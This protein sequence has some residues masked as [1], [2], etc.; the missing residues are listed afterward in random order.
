MAVYFPNQ[1]ILSSSFPVVALGYIP[2]L[3]WI[4]AIIIFL[5]KLLTGNVLGIAKLSRVLPL[6]ICLSFIAIFLF[7]SSINHIFSYFSWQRVSHLISFISEFIILNAALL[8]FI[9]SKNNGFSMCLLGLII[10]ISGDFFVNYSFLSQTTSLL[11]YGELLWY[12][13]LIFILFT[14]KFEK[15]INRHRR[16]RNSI[17]SGKNRFRAVFS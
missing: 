8:C 17:C 13:G 1:Y 11:S 7:F 5:I 12:L 9:Y 3:I 16:G 15:I 6:V 10:L 4:G 14:N 2:Y